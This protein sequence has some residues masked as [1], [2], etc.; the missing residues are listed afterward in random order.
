MWQ[1]IKDRRHDVWVVAALLALPMVLYWQV[2]LGDRTLIPADNLLA[3]EPYASARAQFG[4]SGPA[5]NMLLS[6]LVL[7]NYLWKQF[8]RESIAAGQLPLWNPYLFSGVPFLAAGQHSALYPFS[9]LYYVLPLET[10]YGWFAVS[11]LWLAGLNA[12][13]MLRGFGLR[14][15][16]SGFGA[17]TFELC[18]FLVLSVVFPM[19]VAA[20]AWLPLIVLS[21]EFIARQRTLFGRPATIPWVAL[22]AVAIACQILAGHV[23]ITYYSLLTAG[24]F[25]IWRLLMEGQTDGRVGP[26]VRLI[27]PMAAVAVLGLG[28]AMLQFLPLYELAQSSFRSGRATYEQIL[29]WALP[30]RHILAFFIPN[31]FG[32]SSHHSYF[33]WFSW[34]QVAATT[35]ADTITW[36]VKNTVEG[37]VYL[38]LLPLILAPIGMLAWRRERRGPNANVPFW[39][40]LAVIS[41]TFAFG[42]PLYAA[43]YWLPGLDQVN[44]PFRWVFPLS[45]A[46]AALAAGGVDG[47]QR[48]L[49]CLSRG[50]ALAVMAVGTLALGAL[51]GIRLAY[52]A[53]ADRFDA[54]VAGNDLARQAFSDGR[55]FF[56]YT[57]QWVVVFGLTALASGAA[58]WLA[59]SRWRWRGQERWAL[60]LIGVLAID[61]L[62]A[63]WDFHPKADRAILRYR[64]PS[65]EFLSQDPGPWRM[66]AYD[67]DRRSGS[68]YHANL[69]WYFNFQ[70]VRG[71]DSLFTRAYMTYHSLIQEQYQLAFN[72]IAP[73]DNPSALHSPLLDALN[74]KYVVSATPIDDPQFTLV[75]DGEVRVYRNEDALPRAYTLPASASLRTDAPL[76]ALSETDPHQTVIVE[77]TRADG[78]APLPARAQAATVTLYTPNEVWVDAVVTEPSW[79]I[80]ADNAYPGWRAFVRPRGSA[81]DAEREIAITRVNGIFRGVELAPGDWTVRYRYSPNSLRVGGLISA[82]TGLALLFLF[83]VWAW[84]RVY[85]ADP[86]DTGAQRIAKNALAPMALNVLNRAIDLV[87]AAFYARLL[88]PEQVGNYYFAVVIFS[89]FDIISNYGLNTLLT[90][91]LAAD[92]ARANRYLVNTSILRLWLGFAFI[93]VFAGLLFGL[94]ALAGTSLPLGI[95][96]SPLGAEVLFAVALL[97]LAQAPATLSTGLSALFYAY[98]RA[99]VP[100]AIATVATLL[101]VAISA[102]LLLAGFG[103][104]GLAGSSVIVNTITLGLFSALTVRTFFRPRWEV[105]VDLQRQAL[106][107][108][109]PL[110]LNNLLATLFF[111]VDVTLLRPLRGPVEVG[112]YSMGYRWIE[113]LNLVPSLFTFAL[114]PVLSR[115][116][117]GDKAKVAESFSFAMKLMAATS[118]PLTVAVTFL[119][120]TLVGLLGGGAFLPYG[121]QALIVLAWSMPIGWLNSVTNYVLISL[122][123]ERGLTVSFFWA[124][125][126][127]VS[128]NLLLIPRFGF[129][130]AAAVT[131]VS[132][133]VEGMLFNYFLRRQ[134][135]PVPWLRLVWKAWAAAGAMA[136]VTGLLWPLAP[137]VALLAGALVYAG[138]LWGLRHFSPAERARLHGLLPGRPTR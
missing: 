56:S 42:T 122:R 78:V 40:G 15:G 116:A 76:E 32:N 104:L 113:G 117:A 26:S 34:Q 6:D 35:P 111:K 33:D 107:Q 27:P 25:A 24:A 80:L 87:F 39:V 112:W 88:G 54:F 5:H 119:A 60:V 23:E 73:I 30:T 10:A 74:V 44:S 52:P 58:L 16:A 133:L 57:A 46:V 105:D 1:G 70:D 51:L 90:R 8:I 69:P 37:A 36:G 130:A 7:Q 109:F 108:S 84:R 93:P 49:I 38:G 101:K 48:G 61:L 72:R 123:Q 136:A 125:I 135:G 85:R 129:L 19:I 110:M 53:F 63:G 124:S 47:L 67:L 65:A 120:P 81:G 92:K 41:L 114:F 12:Y 106:R 59:A 31:L 115:Q 79:L 99:E 95:T 131:I 77:A 128:V 100:A 82:T 2:T 62:V 9:L 83:G 66:T 22:G 134:I 94:N 68:P 55:M 14:R 89:W 45:L 4:V 138:L 97:V 18:G 50:L 28:L 103:I 132:E 21:L 91:E 98:E 137:P 86:A 64:P 102:T 11:Q 43:I 96:L 75:Y 126:F 127:N 71:Y 3:Y 118:L 13:L 17:V 20:A 121:A 29:G